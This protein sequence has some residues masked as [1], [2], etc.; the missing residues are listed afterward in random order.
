MKRLI[1]VLLLLISV[2]LAASHIV[3]GEIE[4]LHLSN[5]TYRVNLIYYFDVVHNPNRNIRAEEPTI[6][7]YIFRQSDNVQLLKVTLD[8]LDKT[9]VGYTQPSCSSGEIVTDKIIYTTTIELPAN[10]YSD[11]QGYYITWAR[12][13]RNYSILNIISQ[14]PAHG[15][16]GAGQT[17]YL[18]FPPVTINGQQFINSSPR[19]FPALNDYACPTKP[20]YVN[21][22]G[23]DDDGDSLAYSLV[24][25]LSTVA[26]TAL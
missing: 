4:L 15:G 3:G 20:Y 16:V 22:A 12:C 9:R 11:P 21:F 24:T 18:E 2:P 7:L 17:F 5:F 1:V 13:C 14:D 10:L 6:D 25:P 8:W 19:N 23:T 26:V